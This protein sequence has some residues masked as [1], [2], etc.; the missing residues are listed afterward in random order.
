MAEFKRYIFARQIKQRMFDTD[1]MLT[2][3]PGAKPFKQRSA[4]Y[5]C[6]EIGISHATLSRLLNNSVPD[7]ET[8]GKVCKWLGFAPGEFFNHSA[9][10]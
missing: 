7:I 3:K 2:Q 8:F 6:K 10:K 5:Y 1:F 9:G 4:R